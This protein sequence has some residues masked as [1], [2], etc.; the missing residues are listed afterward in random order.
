MQPCAAGIVVAGFYETRFEPRRKETDRR[1]PYCQPY[2]QRITLGS[3]YSNKTAFLYILEATIAWHE[4][5][6]KAAL[7]EQIAGTN[8]MAHSL[9]GPCSKQKMAVVK[10]RH[11]ALFTGG[12]SWKRRGVFISV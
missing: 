3:K 4:Q 9:Q 5:V 6:K 2:K 8:K 10:P 11:E 1:P 7:S 12:Q